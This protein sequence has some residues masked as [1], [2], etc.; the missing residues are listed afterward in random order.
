MGYRCF[1]VSLMLCWSTCIRVISVPLT[2]GP[3]AFLPI[4]IYLGYST[5]LLYIEVIFLPLK[6]VLISKQIVTPITVVSRLHRWGPGKAQSPQGL[7]TLMIRKTDPAPDC[8]QS[9]DKG[10]CH[11]F[12][13]P[14]RIITEDTTHVDCNV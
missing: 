3:I 6:W 9:N 13:L 2:R 1:E 4:G 8:V 12:W 11:S 10:L 5:I 7:R 14:S